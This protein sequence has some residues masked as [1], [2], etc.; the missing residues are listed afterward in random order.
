M[1]RLIPDLPLEVPKPV[2]EESLE[3]LRTAG[4]DGYELFLIWLG[5]PGD[6]AIQISE[7]VAPAQTM[8]HVSLGCHVHIDGNALFSV[9]QAAA[10]K[11]Y[12][13]CAQVHSHPE[14]AFHSGID[15]ARPI[16][17]LP[18][19]LSLVVPDFAEEPV[20][21][22][23]CALFRMLEDGTWEEI[24]AARWLQVS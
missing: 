24:D 14:E 20:N 7:V 13:V 2:F 4:A 21:L 22:A 15:D 19:S 1:P 12:W 3:L 8:T 17:S 18:G 16:V 11:G 23:K 6:L 5:R 10:A 9:S